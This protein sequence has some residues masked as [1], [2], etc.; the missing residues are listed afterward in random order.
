M[1]S[2]EHGCTLAVQVMTYT[3]QKKVTHN[4]LVYGQ[5]QI[6][7][8]VTS[9]LYIG[10]EVEYEDKNFGFFLGRF[11]VFEKKKIIKTVNTENWKFSFFEHF[12]KLSSWPQVKLINSH[13]HF[14]VFI[15]HRLPVSLRYV[16]SVCNFMFRKGVT[17]YFCIQFLTSNSVWYQYA[18]KL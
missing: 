10:N 16:L 7:V 3:L 14:G 12:S 5:L 9:V 15:F 4:I 13:E 11:N 1:K 17:N 18:Q 6:I 8:A 2:R